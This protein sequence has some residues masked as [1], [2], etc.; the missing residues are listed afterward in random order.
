MMCVCVHYFD[1]GNPI[2]YG[3]PDPIPLLTGVSIQLY[4]LL[5]PLSRAVSATLIY[6]GGGVQ[7][8]G[9]HGTGCFSPW[10][11]APTIL[12]VQH[13]CDHRRRIHISHRSRVN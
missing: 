1:T 4:I 8:G 10:E 6:G 7:A 3:E 9:Q 11:P 2:P 13:C 5:V 12:A